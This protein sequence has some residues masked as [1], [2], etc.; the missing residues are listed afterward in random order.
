MA[1]KLNQ[2]NHLIHIALINNNAWLIT[3]SK[4]G[5]ILE[6]SQLPKNKGKRRVLKKSTRFYLVFYL[7]SY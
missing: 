6:V 3:D 7:I 1:T 4:N 5:V 2:N